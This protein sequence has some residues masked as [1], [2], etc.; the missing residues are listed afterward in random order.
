MIHKIR[1]TSHLFSFYL[2][3]NAENQDLQGHV[4]TKTKRKKEH[5]Q[6]V[7]QFIYINHNPPSV[8]LNY[9][10]IWRMWIFELVCILGV[11]RMSIWIQSCSRFFHPNRPF[12]LWKITIFKVLLCENQHIL[13]LMKIQEKY[14]SRYQGITKRPKSVWKHVLMKTALYPWVCDIYIWN[15]WR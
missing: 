10:H 8:S 11:F 5:L 2:K 12:V 3:T 6:K 1:Q 7:Y 9:Q 15:R 13:C 4:I 14:S